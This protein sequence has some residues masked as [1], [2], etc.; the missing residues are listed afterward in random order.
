MRI[1]AY[2]AAAEAPRDVPGGCGALPAHAP[3]VRAAEVDL[4]RA[5]RDPAGPRAGARIRAAKVRAPLAQDVESGLSE[6]LEFSAFGGGKR[7]CELV[8]SNY[9]RVK[10]IDA[11]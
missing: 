9:L 11:T 10:R 3:F 8:C 5:G 7:V 2:Y 6:W 4:E 1:A